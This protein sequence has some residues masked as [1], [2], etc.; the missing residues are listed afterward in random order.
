MYKKLL[1]IALASMMLVGCKGPQP[2]GPTPEE[3]VYT[4]TEEQYNSEFASYK[5]FDIGSNV[6]VNMTLNMSDYDVNGVHIV[7]KADNGRYYDTNDSD[8][9]ETFYNY[10]GT[11]EDGR[12]RFQE[13]YR[14]KD[15]DYE[16]H[17]T[18]VSLKEFIRMEICIIMPDFSLLQFDE[19]K[20]CYMTKE[21]VSDGEIINKL[22]YEEMYFVDGQLSK[23]LIKIYDDE[24]PQKLEGEVEQE[25]S[26]YGKTRVII[27]NV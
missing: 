22:F 10:L 9:S 13:Y 1:F 15:G 17:I 6:T 11:E 23:A 25:Y 20:Q 24:D 14:E 5:F 19:Q 16:K 12:Y 27:P 8:Y 21:L 18:K 4:I 2:L 3:H 7:V 26:E